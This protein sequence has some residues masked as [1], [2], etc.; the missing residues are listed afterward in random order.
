MTSQGV[1]GVLLS[2]RL[3]P[4]P[5]SRSSIRARSDLSP[6]ERAEVD[7]LFAAAF[8]DGVDD[9]AWA[10]SEWYVL[11][12]NL[13]GVLTSMIEILERTVTVDGQPVRVGGIGGVGTHPDYRRR[14]H[15]TAA[16]RVAADFLRENLAVPFGLLVTGEEEIPF[17]G[18]LGWRVASPAP[19]RSTSPAIE[20]SSAM[21]ST[22]CCPSAPTPGHPAPS[23]SAA[24]RGRR[25]SSRRKAKVYITCVID[26]SPGR[27]WNRAGGEL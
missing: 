15:S 6:T 23:I 18:R 8:A 22:W 10:T 7:A 11:V 25:R 21:A 9:L 12:R 27:C 3:S 4:C 26:V 17:Y 24:Y 2:W 16:L 19:S 1:S 13:D 14:G 20:S 5:T